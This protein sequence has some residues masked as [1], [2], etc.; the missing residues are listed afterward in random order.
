MELVHPRASRPLFRNSSFRC[1][2]NRPILVPQVLGLEPRALSVCAAVCALGNV[3]GFG[4]PG[5]FGRDDVA[6]STEA[7]WIQGPRELFFCDDGA[8]IDKEAGR[9]DRGAEWRRNEV[10]DET[11]TRTSDRRGGK[12]DVGTDYSVGRRKPSALAQTENDAKTAR[13]INANY[14]MTTNKALPQPSPRS[15]RPGP[16]NTGTTYFIAMW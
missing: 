12:S 13:E 16:P 7:C 1:L 8:D 15:E 11:L 14:E 2:W 4:A 10:R 9:L 3:L 6:R 5:E